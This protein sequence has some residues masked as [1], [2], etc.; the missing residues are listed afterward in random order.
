MARERP[1]RET[2]ERGE[3]GKREREENKVLQLEEG[4]KAVSVRKYLCLLGTIQLCIFSFI[5]V[6]SETSQTGLAYIK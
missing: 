2:I 4:C 5:K 3:K 6:A 1:Q